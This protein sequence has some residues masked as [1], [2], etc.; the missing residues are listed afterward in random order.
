VVV[1]MASRGDTA[2]QRSSREH[3]LKCLSP[4]VLDSFE[5]HLRDRA[6][7]GAGW[8]LNRPVPSAR[9]GAGWFVEPAGP[10]RK[11]AGNRLVSQEREPFLPII[12]NQPHSPHP[13]SPFVPN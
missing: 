7:E 5:Q 4:R 8:L 2:P 3:I 6:R 10:T 13:L 1:L 9:E 12:R 11:G